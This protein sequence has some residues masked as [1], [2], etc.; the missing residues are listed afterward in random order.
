MSYVNAFAFHVRY[1][2]IEFVLARQ[3]ALKTLLLITEKRSKTL[4]RI[5]QC[6]LKLLKS[7]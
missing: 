7:F 1:Y 5:L 3:I 4:I 2:C 6:E